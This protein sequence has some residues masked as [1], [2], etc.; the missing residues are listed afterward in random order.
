MR[1]FCLLPA[2]CLLPFTLADAAEIG[3]RNDG[4]G[5]FPES[6]PPLEWASGV[7]IRWESPLPEWGNSMPVLVGDRIFLTCEPNLLV[8]LS[9]ES[10]EI[11]WS[12]ATVME[13]ALDAEAIEKLERNRETIATLQADL[14]K[15]RQEQRGMRR[16]IRQAKGEE[17]EQLQ[18]RRSELSETINQK[19]TA[20]ANMGGLMKPRTH[21][22]NG[23]SS[24]TPV[25]DGQSV[26]AVF[27]TGVVAAFDLDGNRL[28]TVLHEQPTHPLGHSTSP[29][30]VDGLLVVHFLQMMALSPN[31]GSIVWQADVENAWGTAAVTEIGGSPVLITPKGNIVRAEDGRILASELFTL[32]YGCPIV[33][34]GVLYAVDETGGWAYKIPERLGGDSVELELLWRNNPPRDR[35]YSSPIVVD[36]ILY[37][38]NRAQR[39]SAI[40]IHTGDILFSERI[41]F[42]KGQQ[43]YGSFS[44][45]GGHLFVSHDNGQVAVLKP[46]NDYE[47]VATNT[48]EDSRS[49]PIFVDEKIFYR[50][51]RALYCIAE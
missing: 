21:E 2:L 48:L 24:P 36:D 26:Y 27:G 16:K 22:A 23:Y 25:S 35:Y 33:Q 51:S 7:N 12:K 8:C 50:T 46:G 19:E 29:R 41:P 18:A 47:L 1:T 37:A 14:V 31:D 9:A 34:D 44:L 30:L 39:V 5:L 13:D 20:L 45:A 32:P 43:L 15:L 40:D 4:S 38:C 10:G 6:S 11:L 17:K 42:G 3:W 49:T 28:W